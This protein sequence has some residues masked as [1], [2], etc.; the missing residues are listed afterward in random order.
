MW[1][2]DASTQQWLHSC[3]L[4]SE[5]DDTGR[6]EPW[7]DRLESQSEHGILLGVGPHLNS[8]GAPG[9]EITEI[10][11][12]AAA[13]TASEEGRTRLTPPVSS[14]AGQSGLAQEAASNIRL[15]ALPLCSKHYQS[16]SQRQTIPQ[17]SPAS[18]VQDFYYNPSP[19]P[20]SPNPTD[21]PPPKR[22][23]IE[24]LFEDATQ[25][26]RLQKKRGGEGIAKAMAAM[27]NRMAMPSLPSSNPPEATQP[28]KHK[29]PATKRTPLSRAT[30]TGSM[31][32]FPRTDAF[33]PHQR[34]KSR[35]PTLSEGQR[36][37]LHHVPNASSPSL[38]SELPN[39]ANNDDIES[40]N[41]ATL[42]R[43]IMAGM[44]M[45]GFQQ[46]RKKSVS[47]P[48]ETQSQLA[49]E[50]DE[51]KAIYHQTFKAA[52]F[53][54]RASWGKRVLGQEALRETVDTFLGRFCQDPL[55]TPG[56]GHELNG[57][58]GS[59]E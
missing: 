27:D 13:S 33:I 1:T 44:R 5:D 12:Y 6:S 42:S 3:L 51:Y 20:L 25:N 57:V 16:L 49:T 48:F 7:R 14:S 55:A 29:S 9:P 23:R 59:Q 17:L 26:R 34:P 47:G 53:V 21:L 46:Q 8:Q 54:F 45:Y 15:Y 50:Q 2:R 43:I 56:H 52:S 18:N 30:T 22:P 38:F 4:D 24:S 39:D 35:R 41:K 32:P 37:S 36:S 28:E 10:L 19:I 58:F 40:Q 31:N 11:L